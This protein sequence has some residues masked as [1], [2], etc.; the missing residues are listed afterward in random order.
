MD[1]KQVTLNLNETS[2]TL[3]HPTVKY[4]DGAW[5]HLAI[6]VDAAAGELTLIVDTISYALRFTPIGQLDLK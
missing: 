5:H 6:N 4:N 1:E 3:G 2:L